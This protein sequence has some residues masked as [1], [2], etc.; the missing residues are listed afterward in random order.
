MK[1]Y[2]L[3]AVALLAAGCNKPSR[4]TISGKAAG[5]NNAVFSVTDV[6]GENIV[7]ENITNGAFSGDVMLEHPGYGSFSINQN[8]AE[9]K[10]VFEVY[11]E[12]GKYDVDVDAAKLNDYPK[13]TS[14]SKIQQELSAYYALQ[15]EMSGEAAKVVNVYNKKAKT[16]DPAAVSAQEYRE[17]LNRLADANVKLEEVKLEALKA[18]VAKNPE[19]TVTA[20]LMNNLDYKAA[21]AAFN[22]LYSKLS[23]EAKNSD[24]GKEIGAKLALLMKLLPGAVAPTISGTSP[25]GKK[26]DA[27]K[28]DK[29]LYVVD[30]WKAGNDLSRKNHKDMMEGVM[31]NYS[32]KQVG[33]ISISLDNKHDWWTKAIADDH[34]T[35]PQYS[36]LKGNESENAKNWM[37][38]TIPMFYLVDGK[39]RVVARDVEFSRL[40]FNIKESLNKL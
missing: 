11:L 26:F 5:L 40:D 1:L 20:H 33:F 16:I 3:L 7:G 14:A 17:L 8:G 36:D 37:I 27:G 34:L 32:G 28:L 29:K 4:L 38:T 23:T 21:P 30:F 12:P 19:S 15:N 2:Y 31:R 24:E 35:W 13:I 6:A 39:W 25:D 18:F 22:N 10:N 9:Q